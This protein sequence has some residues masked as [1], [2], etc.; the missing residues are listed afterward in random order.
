KIITSNNE[1]I[2]KK[3]SV[4]WKDYLEKEENNSLVFYS[5]SLNVLKSR[6]ELFGYTFETSKKAFESSLANEILRYERDYMNHDV[7]KSTLKIFKEMTLNKWLSTL[8]EIHEQELTYKEY[9]KNHNT[10]LSS[11]E[12]DGS[13]SYIEDASLLGYML[14]NEDS[15]YGFPGDSI[16]VALRLCLEVIP[17]R[18]D[19]VYDV[20]DLILGGYFDVDEDLVEY[21]TNLSSVEYYDIG[22]CIILTEGKS[23]KF[24]LSES[25]SL[26]YPHL[27]EYFTFMDFEGAKVGGGAGSLA[28]IVKSFSSVGI[29]N[30]VIAVFDNDTAAHAALKGIEKS[31]I[32][33]NIKI[34]ILPNIDILNDYPTIGPSGEV[35]MNVNGM[36]GSIEPYLGSECISNS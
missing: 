11:E 14:R 27:A 32:S 3:I 22:K 18:D 12:S 23:D 6:L 19:L 4:V 7:F 28:N 1:R 33:N 2:P 24:I 17:E 10:L 13:L 21:V 26:L 15:F 5:I 36:A 16:Y 25:L 30:K 8:K 9:E 29:I 35:N 34:F 31:K 20:G